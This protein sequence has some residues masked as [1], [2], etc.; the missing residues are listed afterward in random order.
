MD[1]LLE[2]AKMS[3]MS[4]PINSDEEDISR[5]TKRSRQ[6]ARIKHEGIQF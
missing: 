6:A 3:A 5:P 1:V 2:E 4:V